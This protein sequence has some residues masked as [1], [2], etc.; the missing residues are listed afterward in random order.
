[1][2][3]DSLQ[4]RD[5]TDRGAMATM[6]F[7]STNNKMYNVGDEYKLASSFMRS[8]IQGSRIGDRSQIHIKKSNTTR[9]G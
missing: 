6:T 7:E 3:L 2:R 4:G 1:M 9:L 5:Y 8:Q